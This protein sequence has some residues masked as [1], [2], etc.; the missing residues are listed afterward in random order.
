MPVLEPR[1]ARLP[2][3]LQKGCFYF[4]AHNT[5]TVWLKRAS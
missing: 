1:C 5:G 4:A 3:S 2:I